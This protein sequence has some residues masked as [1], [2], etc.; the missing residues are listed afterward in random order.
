MEFDR[1]SIAAL[2]L[3]RWLLDPSRQAIEQSDDFRAEA[4]EEAGRMQA[5]QPDQFRYECKFVS[6]VRR[7]PAP[8]RATQAFQ[9]CLARAHLP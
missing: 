1:K 3:S 7:S 6:L 2:I 8:S 5:V 9:D 4:F